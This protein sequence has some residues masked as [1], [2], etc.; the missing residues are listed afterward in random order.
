MLNILSVLLND[1]YLD[2]AVGDGVAGSYLPKGE[3]LVDSGV[4]A[5]PGVDGVLGCEP[6]CVFV[7]YMAAKVNVFH[8][9]TGENMRRLVLPN[10]DGAVLVGGT[11][12]HLKRFEVIQ[13]DVCS[14]E[15][16][17]P[18][19]NAILSADIPESI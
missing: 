16:L 5:V 4:K 2:T 14:V 12:R 8:G 19:E 6:Y 11:L 17:E 1:V 13:G 7:L 3:Y 15:C 18:W 9:V 10:E